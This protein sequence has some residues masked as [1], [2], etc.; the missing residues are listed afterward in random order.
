MADDDELPFTLTDL[1][2]AQLSREGLERFIQQESESVTRP[3]VASAA[4]AIC[5]VRRRIQK[6]ERFVSDYPWGDHPFSQ[7]RRRVTTFH[8]EWRDVAVEVSSIRESDAEVAELQDLQ[9]RGADLLARG[10]GLALEVRAL[11]RMFPCHVST[12]TS[13]V[14]YPTEAKH[15]SEESELVRGA[16]IADLLALPRPAAREVLR[17]LN[18]HGVSELA[19]KRT[20]AIREGGG[21]EGRG[22]ATMA[23][24]EDVM[25]AI[26]TVSPS[27]TLFDAFFR[28]AGV[29]CLQPRPACRLC[30][31]HRLLGTQHVLTHHLCHVP[32]GARH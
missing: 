5:M 14:V 30:E 22:R 19:Q 31:V 23:V 6:N 18:P 9:R 16:T 2:F 25:Y 3:V 26:L 24:R 4:R 13:T 15:A 10:Y 20:R 27:G 7:F 8:D 32:H 28:P 1:A 12:F 11:R 17:C 21:D 29:F